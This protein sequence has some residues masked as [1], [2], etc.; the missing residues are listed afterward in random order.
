VLEGKTHYLEFFGNLQP[1]TK[2]GEQLSHKFYAFRE[3]RLPFNVRVRDPNNDAVGERPLAQPE[4]W[5]GGG[6]GKRIQGR[7]VTNIDVQRAKRHS[8]QIIVRQGDREKR[9][10]GSQMAEKYDMK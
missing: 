2:S 6:R 4:G 3:N 10:K 9:W 7:T 8:L 5:R 1:V